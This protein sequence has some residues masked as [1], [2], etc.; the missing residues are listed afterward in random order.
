MAK[1][2][3][4]IEY[5]VQ[6][7]LQGGARL[8]GV[9]DL[10]KLV[11]KSIVERITYR[12]AGFKYK[13]TESSLQNVAARLFKELSSIIGVPINRRNFLEVIEKELEVA[14][15]I[16][17]PGVEEIVFDRIQANFWIRAGRAAI[18]SVGY[19]ARQELEMTGYL[20]QYSPQF[21]ATFCVDVSEKA[22]V[23]EILWGL[24]GTLQIPLPTPRSNVAVLLKSIAAV[25]QL[26]PTLLVLRFDR[27]S[28]TAAR[29]DRRDFAEMLAE[30]ALMEWS[31]SLLVIDRDPVGN[32][33]ELRRSLGYQL[34]NKLDAWGKVPF[35]DK[36]KLLGLR[37]VSIEGDRQVI[38][39]LLQTYLR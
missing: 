32:E 37:L 20:I 22:S 8:G 31:G 3:E 13:Y 18:V 14:P 15:V 27:L 34:R 7:L 26:R 11:I 4:S 28:P 36:R 35:G 21:E 2:S 25:L 23:L 1:D 6:R 33:L 29:P 12:Q 30:I 9:T 10:E 39:D 16:K 38:C 5:V 19:S 17:V 24:C